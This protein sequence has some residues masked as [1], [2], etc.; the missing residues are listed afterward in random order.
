V[1]SQ[2]F[3]A[4]VSGFNQELTLPSYS[5]P[6]LQPNSVWN[7]KAIATRT[8]SYGCPETDRSFWNAQFAEVAKDW[9]LCPYDSVDEVPQVLG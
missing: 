3:V 5:I 8:R 7:N 2:D 4:P 1:I 9:L 6:E